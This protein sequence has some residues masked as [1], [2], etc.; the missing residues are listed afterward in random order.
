M[1]AVL[2][3]LKINWKFVALMLTIVG[4]I[5]GVKFTLQQGPPNVPPEVIII[6]P[7]DDSNAWMAQGPAA[8]EARDNRP[9]LF[10]I[11]RIKAA[12]M[13]HQEHPDTP[14]LQCLGLARAVP[15]AEVVNA[16]KAAGIKFEG[17]PVGGPLQNLLDWIAAHPEVIQQIIQIILLLI[18]LFA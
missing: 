3:W 11:A 15:E 14:F 1:T 5:F 13:Y 10:A 16:V 6:V 9:V 18:P 12:R 4:G 17:M 8:V 2:D 7:G